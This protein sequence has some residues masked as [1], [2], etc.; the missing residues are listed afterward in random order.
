VA[1]TRDLFQTS[2]KYA[3]GFLE[4]LDAKGVTRRVD[5]KRMLRQE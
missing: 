4:H 3:L 5:D 2:R 1:E